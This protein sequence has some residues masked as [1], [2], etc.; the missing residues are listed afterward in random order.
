MSNPLAC[1]CITF[2]DNLG[3]RLDEVLPA[4]AAAGFA[5]VEVGYRHLKDVPPEV[6]REKLQHHEQVLVASHVG[7]NL[8]DTDQATGERG[9]LDAVIDL[10]AALDT[11]L[12]MYSGLQYRDDKQLQDDLAMLNRA[13]ARCN[14]AGIRLCYH[15][16]NWEFD[17]DGAVMEALLT[18]GDPSLAFCPDVGWVAKAGQDVPALLTRMGP[19]VAAI[20]FKDFASLGPDV[21]TVELGEG[22]VPLAEAAAWVKANRPEIWVIAEQDKA[23]IPADRAVHKNGTCLHALFD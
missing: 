4:V 16:H 14:E 3:A 20:H 6:I 7:G 21:D 5:G 1:Q 10:L 2:G 18:D 15:N 23:A 9:M 13:A 19:R 11:G 22:V 12:L 17:H 8:E